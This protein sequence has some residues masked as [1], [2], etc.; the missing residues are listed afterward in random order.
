MS[1]IYFLV[2]FAWKFDPDCPRGYLGPG[3]LYNNAEHPHCT[4]GA[5][6]KLDKLVLGEKHLYQ[7]FTASKLY[8]PNG[9]YGL[10][11]DPEGILGLTTSILLTLLGLQVGKTLLA[12]SSV[13]Q[14]L[15]RWSA[16]AIVL[17]KSIGLLFNCELTF[18]P[19]PSPSFNSHY[20]CSVCH[21]S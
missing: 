7:W 18:S 16:L 2:T 15:Q 13:Q 3:G 6:N 1:L 10:T 14:R 4:G 5:A 21:S 9:M 11:H 8:D 20:H 12:Y 19:F 17:G